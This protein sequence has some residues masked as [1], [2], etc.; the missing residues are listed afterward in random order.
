ML[1]AKINGKI[2]EGYTRQEIAKK[3]VDF[4]LDN[5]SY[6][7]VEWLSLIREAEYSIPEKTF[8]KFWNFVE[9]MYESRIGNYLAYQERVR[10]QQLCAR[11]TYG[12][13]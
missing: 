1:R 7:V 5:E 8:Y 2:Y 10:E 6:P 13:I 12:R 3:A 9:K 4:C 11:S